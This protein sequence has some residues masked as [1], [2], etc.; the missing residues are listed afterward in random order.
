MVLSAELSAAV[1]FIDSCF[2]CSEL[3]LEE[4]VVVSVVVERRDVVLLSVGGVWGI[5]RRR[6]G[7]CPPSFCVLGERPDVVWHCIPVWLFTMG[8]TEQLE[9]I[10]FPCVALKGSFHVKVFLPH[11]SQVVVQSSH[12]GFQAV[13]LFHLKLAEEHADSGT[14]TVCK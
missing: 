10:D 1:L 8:E 6:L 7:L 4:S 11:I 3:R 12:D 5:G 14:T 2:D 9:S 13:R